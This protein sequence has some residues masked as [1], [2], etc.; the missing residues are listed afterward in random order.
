MTTD[1]PARP[2]GTSES[3]RRATAGAL[4]VALA[5]S[6]FA[7]GGFGATSRAVFAA[8][9]GAALLLAL[10]ADVD[11]AL[12]AARRVPV[13][14]LAA[15]AAAAALSALW[16]LG[17][18][19]RALR[20]SLVVAGYGAIAVAAAT[21]AANRDGLR[22]LAIALAL[23][24]SVAGVLGIAGVAL[25]GS[26]MALHMNGEWQA[27]GP[28]EYPPA[29]ALA[30]LTAMPILLTAMVK[31]RAVIAGAAAGGLAVAV[32]ATLLASTRVGLALALIVLIASLIRAD[33]LRA[34]RP[35]VA[36]AWAIAVIPPALLI[37][38]ADPA[39]PASPLAGDLAGALALAFVVALAALAWPR[40]RSSIGADA[41]ATTMRVRTQLAVVAILVVAGAAVASTTRSGPGVESSSEWTHGRVEHWRAASATA[42]IT[43]SSGWAQTRT[44][45]VRR[46]NRATTPFS[47]RTRCRSS[48]G[49]SSVCSVSPPRSLSICRRGARHGVLGATRCC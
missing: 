41:V 30:E 9:A 22:F 23:T 36:S 20:W 47:T 1:V 32:T 21:V 34:S 28:F 42:S 45:A 16:T 25:R 5:V 26:P 15:I 37:A 6:V 33:L 13:L 35:A 2:A 4:A 14:A 10:L 18:P 40:V 31:A 49:P 43:R 7:D 27:A 19:A 3:A 44:S 8:I 12:E 48:S 38:V 11:R 39:D 17:D 46:R 29:L 24:A